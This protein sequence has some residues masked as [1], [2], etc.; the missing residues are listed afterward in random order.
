[1]RDVGCWRL[2]VGGWKLKVIRRKLEG[3]RTPELVTV[4]VSPT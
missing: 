4:R 3:G 2:E 1:M